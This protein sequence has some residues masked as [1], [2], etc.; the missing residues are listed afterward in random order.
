MT[1]K[2]NDNSSWKIARYQLE[3]GII[4]NLLSDSEYQLSGSDF[5]Y[6]TPLTELAY[7]AQQDRNNLNVKITSLEERLAQLQAEINQLKNTQE[8]Y[9]TK[10]YQYVYE[11]K[12]CP[13]AYQPSPEEISLAKARYAFD[14]EIWQTVYYLELYINSLEGK[15]VKF[16][17]TKE[18]VEK[19]AKKA[20][21]DWHESLKKWNDDNELWDCFVDEEWFKIVYIYGLS[22]QHSG[23]CT[24]FACSCSRCHAEGIFK[25]PY[26]ANWS[27]S[28]GYKME[29]AF[30]KDFQSKK[31]LKDNEK[32]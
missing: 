12:L 19:E 24:A 32:S 30:L 20:L 5:D 2:N 11:D 4:E 23:D 7:K 27:K 8:K 28:E 14:N 6:K 1:E 9:K 16:P 21:V 29:N 25:I 18:S 17:Y 31:A 10:E 3:L 26:T 15:E 22:D 13:P